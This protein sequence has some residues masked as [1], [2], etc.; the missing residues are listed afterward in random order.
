[1]DKRF[2]VATAAVLMIPT[3]CASGPELLAKH[4]VHVSIDGKDAGGHPVDCTQVGWLWNLETLEQTPGLIAQVRT[5]DPVVARSVQINNLGG[6]TGSFWDKT[7]GEAEASLV[8]GKFTI[9][10][11]AVG[12]F[13][14]DPGERTTAPFEISTD[15]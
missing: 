13:H 2:A 15:C 12:F 5:G 6:F 3:G 9:T 1:M 14:D 7:T 4:L 11:T 10:G 8:D